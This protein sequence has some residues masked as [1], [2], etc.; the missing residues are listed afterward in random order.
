MS[1]VD[2]SWDDAIDD[3][4]AL[5]VDDAALEASPTDR[6]AGSVLAFLADSVEELAADEDADTKDLPVG[7]VPRLFARYRVTTDDENEQIRKAA[8]RRLKASGQ[9]RR[10]KPQQQ[11]EH[12]EVERYADALLLATSCVEILWQDDEGELVSLADAE[13]I[14]GPLRYDR[15]MARYCRLDRSHGLNLDTC[16]AAEVVTAL[17]TWAGGSTTPLTSTATVLKL[18]GGSVLAAALQE[19]LGED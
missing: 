8:R 13:G 19:A 17:H 2:P 3:D 7:K 14:A 9:V 4:G 11:G 12:P 15:E 5:V 16:T 18:W 1:T 10:K 6:P